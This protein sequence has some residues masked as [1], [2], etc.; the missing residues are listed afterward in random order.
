MILILILKMFVNM[1]PGS[2]RFHCTTLLTLFYRRANA[3]T[4]TEV[5]TVP[6]SMPR[7]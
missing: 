7:P 2:E 5:T 3:W 6:N 4:V 1:G